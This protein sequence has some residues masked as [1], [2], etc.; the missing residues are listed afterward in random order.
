MATLQKK[1]LIIYNP[2][3]GRLNGAALSHKIANCLEENGV[4][5]E[6]IEIFNS[7]SV[8]V[9]DEYFKEYATNNKSFTAAAVIGGDGTIGP[10]ANALIVNNIDLPICCFGR[11]T[12]NDFSAYYKTQV[13][14]KKF[15][16]ILLNGKQALHDLIN[17]NG[18]IAVSHTSGGAFTNGVKTYNRSSKRLFGKFAYYIEACLEAPFLKTQS[19]T[20]M[21]DGA[22]FTERCFMFT[23]TTTNHVA[24][25]KGIAKHSVTDD[26]ILDLVIIK[27]CGFFSK[28]RIGIDMIFGT[29]Y[30]NKNVKYIRAKTF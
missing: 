7:H 16:N 19:V 22:V 4:P 28:L 12:A 27:K 20:F 5:A 30:K 3:A 17:V 14:V 21:A 24:G 9:L 10:V 13:S 1:F 25:I 18:Q 26:G 29:V 6:N 8:E 15:V 2:N 23:I 11:G